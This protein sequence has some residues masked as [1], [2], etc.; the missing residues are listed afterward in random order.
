MRIK[1]ATCSST[2]VFS[3]DHGDNDTTFHCELPEGH[4]GKHLETGSLYGGIYTVKWNK[5]WEEVDAISQE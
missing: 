4:S 1:K 5:G 3:D 2:F